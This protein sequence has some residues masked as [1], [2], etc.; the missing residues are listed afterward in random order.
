MDAKVDTIRSDLYSADQMESL[1]KLRT[2][3]RVAAL[4]KTL[5]PPHQH[6][7]IVASKQE[8]QRA[9]LAL[10][11]Q[12]AMQ[13]S[14]AAHQAAIAALESKHQMRVDELQ[15]KY[16]NEWQQ[17]VDSLQ[18]RI[19]ELEDQRSQDRATRDQ[20]EST[21]AQLSSD[22]SSLESAHRSAL[23][24][25]DTHQA[26]ECRFLSHIAAQTAVIDKLKTMLDA[27]KKRVQHMPHD[28]RNKLHTQLEEDRARA[29]AER[30]QL[31]HQHAQ[32]IAD[33]QS[34]RD[35]DQ[36]LLHEANT[37]RESREAHH[38][39]ILDQWEQRLAS[40]LSQS[41][42][43]HK[44][45]WLSREQSWLS[46]QQQRESLIEAKIATWEEQYKHE[47]ALRE[48]KIKECTDEIADLTS[49]TKQLREAQHTIDRQAKET[50]HLKIK[51]HQH[52]QR[53][54]ARRAP[55]SS[56]SA[57]GAGSWSRRALSVCLSVCLCVCVSD[58]VF[59]FLS[60]VRFILR[61]FALSA[62][63]ASR[64]SPFVC[65]PC[66]TSAPCSTRL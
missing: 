8:S 39:L 2:D 46:E 18:R 45:L 28:E 12:L 30:D 24:S 36:R 22:L 16:A 21:R 23:S 58:C 3:E 48:R 25:V 35:T 19:A 42:Q 61:W 9:R 6:E 10:E 41:A 63:S 51:C 11:F 4:A 32:S 47:L 44:S 38:R 43:S 17:H 55:A 65:L 64:C 56:G 7:A 66:P 37:Q 49:A 59:S 50:A 60:C 31:K 40:E 15:G 20:L 33:L 1:V 34:L 52:T 5:V 27:E 13:T 53:V 29:Q 14:E 57:G 26:N 54:S 62:T